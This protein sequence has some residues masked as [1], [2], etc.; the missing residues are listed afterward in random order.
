MTDNQSFYTQKVNLALDFIEENFEMK[1]TTAQLADI[2]AFSEFHFHRIFKAIT[3][4]TVNRYVK[5]LKMSKSRRTLTLDNKPITEVAL[6]Y[7]YT[8]SANFAR[9]FKQYFDESASSVRDKRAST[10]PLPPDGLN[11]SYVGYR[12]YPPFEVIYKRVMTGYRPLEIRKAFQELLD[13]IQKNNLPFES[14]RSYG[15]GYDDPD[16]IDPDKCRYDACVT[17]DKDVSY[18]IESFNRKTVNPGRCLVYLLEGKSEDFG[19]AWD[20]VFKK[21]IHTEGIRPG[22]SPH[23]EEYVASERYEEGIFKAFLF[24]PVLPLT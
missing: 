24:L 16:F 2:S 15:I 8:S 12:D 19:R 3:G 4:E 17:V 21:V 7:G 22:D 13:W 10:D 1:I 5:R 18:D 20:Y 9:D 6:D 14:V 23:F 11:L